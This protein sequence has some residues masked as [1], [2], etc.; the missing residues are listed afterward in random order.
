MA[1]NL[2]G[3]FLLLQANP[4]KAKQAGTQNCLHRVT[5]VVDGRPDWG[6][7]LKNPQ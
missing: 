5:V 3:R 6:P 7:R 1:V 2:L 4:P